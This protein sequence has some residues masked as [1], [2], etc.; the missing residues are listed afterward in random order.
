V[1]EADQDRWLTYVELGQLLG[2]SSTAARM[3]AARRRSWPRRPPNMIGDHTRVLV[4]DDAGSVPRRTMHTTDGD[5]RTA[6]GFDRDAGTANSAAVSAAITALR[7]QLAAVNATLA[8]ERARVDDLL[9]DL[10]DARSAERI[11]A[12]AAA[13]LRHEI[14]LLRA[15]PWWRRWFR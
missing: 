15:R 9:A 4:P 3:H 14:E 5:Q 7:E 13:A 11:S 6:N 8:A 12:D 10:A 1:P 2:I